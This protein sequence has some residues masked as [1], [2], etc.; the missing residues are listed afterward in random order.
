MKTNSYVP[1]VVSD[2]YPVVVRRLFDRIGREGFDK[3]ALYGFGENMKWLYRILSERGMK[4]S[5]CDWRKE[6]IGYDCGGSTVASI[7]ALEDNP[8]VLG[9]VC[10]EEIHDQKAAMRYVL[11]KGWTKMPFIYDRAEP[12]KP[13]LQ[14]QPYKGILERAKARAK[15]MIS[16]EQLFDLIQYIKMVK[17]VPG[18]VVEFG[19]YMGGSGAVLVE[20]VK[21]YTGGKKKV[22]LFDTF[23]GIPKSKYGLDHHW[24]SSFANNSYK[25]V[26]KAVSDCPNVTVIQGNIMETHKKA[27]GEISFGYLASDTLESGEALLNFMWPKLSPGGIVC[28]C[29]YG[30]YPNCVPLTMY[31]DKWLEGRKDALVFMPDKCGIFIMKRGR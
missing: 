23:A 4:A 15:S 22:L 16:D 27:T 31:T 26:S 25:E 3:I 12:H 14:E 7:D 24:N 11:E 29:D 9:V 21:H 13:Y 17:D 8:S 10:V 28:V 18:D 6:F 30:S 19:S 1:V 2:Y 20:A 5:L